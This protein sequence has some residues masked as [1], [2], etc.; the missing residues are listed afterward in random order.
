MARRSCNILT[1]NSVTALM[2]SH[3]IVK[4]NGTE[5]LQHSNHEL[6]H[7]TDDV[8]QH[9]ETL[10]HG[11]ATQSCSKT[12][13]TPVDKGGWLLG[14]EHHR[15]QHNHT[16]ARGGGGARARRAPHPTQSHSLIGRVD[17]QGGL[18]AKGRT[19]TVP[20]NMWVRLSWLL[21]EDGCKREQCTVPALFS[22]IIGCY[23][24]LAD[25]EGR[26]PYPHRA[27]RSLAWCG[28]DV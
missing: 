4:L 14:R 20:C 12:S 17:W 7:R 6:Y 15:T 11:G 25:R 2:T 13:N 22:G 26:A 24:V 19:E 21:R 18:A 16:M 3:N 9:R 5:A 1:M 8:T 23:G 10:W 27:L 28:A